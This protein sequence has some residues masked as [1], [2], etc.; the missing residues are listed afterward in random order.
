MIASEI[1]GFVVLFCAGILAGEEFVI[2]FGVRT[3]LASLEER[4]QMQLRQVLIRRLRV[5]VPGIFVPTIVSGVAVTL[6]GGF[7]ITFVIRCAA[8]LGLV[9]WTLVTLQGTAPIN[10]AIAEWNPDAPL[11]NWREQ[12]NKWERFASV[13]PWASMFA[14]AM[15]LTAVAL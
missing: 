3:P 5:L 15:F 7:G 1:L 13:R 6:L 12:V 9:A 10:S 2:Y 4:P 14:F 8:L 11:K